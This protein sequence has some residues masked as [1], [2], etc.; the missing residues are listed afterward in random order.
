MK[1][2]IPVM[3]FLLA[4]LLFG[5]F[6]GWLLLGN[7]GG[8]RAPDMRISVI[9]YGGEGS[10][11]WDT[12]EQGIRQACRELEIENPVVYTAPA[13]DSHAQIQL[14]EQ[15]AGDGA[16]GLLIAPENSADIL[17]L[18]DSLSADVPFVLLKSGA[19]SYSFIGADDEGMA[20]LLAQKLAEVPGTV[21]L[22]QGNTQRS[23]LLIRQRV[24]LA[25]MESLGKRVEISDRM[26][27]EGIAVALDTAALDAAV[28]AERAEA[29]T[30]YGIGSKTSLVHAL[31]QGLL[32]GIVYQNEYA[33]GY[34]AMMRLAVRLGLA[35]PLPG[36]EVQ[37][38][39]VD[40]D[41]MFT[42]DAERLLFPIAQ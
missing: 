39:Y 13:G 20:R 24:F 42:P 35:E 9:M 6:M 14:I 15:E 31:N 12:L 3:L 19:G 22:L 2:H 10:A 27:Q 30:L 16:A 28:N 5:L 32:Q 29:V 11:R 25:E 4:F 33:I 18:L 26:P 1:K 7:T 34:M 41:T 17:P 36:N 37:F 23:N 8:N 38:L 40:R 21:T